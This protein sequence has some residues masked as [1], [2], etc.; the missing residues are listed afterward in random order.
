VKRC[1]KCRE[2]KDLSR[3]SKKKS[4]SDGLQKWCKDCVNSYN[5]QHFSK[6]DVR[7]NKRKTNNRY[8]REHKEQISERGKEY[9]SR[10]EFRSRRRNNDNLPTVRQRI[11]EC[12]NNNRTRRRNNDSA[13][14]LICNLR[15]RNCKV[16]RGKKNITARDGIG[17]SVEELVT[18]IESQWVEGM[19]WS[20]YGNKEG[21]WSIDHIFPFHL[22]DQNDPDAIVR[23]N[24]YTNLRPMW[25]I[26]NISRTYEEFTQKLESGV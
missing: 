25:H 22:C 18:H 21:Q 2:E 17:C 14:K 19:D 13:Y 10:P 16:I 12:D 23:N 3:F 20:N 24:H 8:Y 11:R 26:D 7:S 9:R 1:L 15:S 6:P 4:N 5:L